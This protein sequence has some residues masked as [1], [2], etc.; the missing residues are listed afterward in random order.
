M[1]HLPSLP[2]FYTIGSKGTRSP[3]KGG[4]EDER[5]TETVRD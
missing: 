3:K 2:L 5:R 4:T 1:Y